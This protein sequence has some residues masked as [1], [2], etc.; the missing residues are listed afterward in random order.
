MRILA[1]GKFADLDEADGDYSPSRGR[2]RG[3]AADREGP[4]LPDF[5]E[6]PLDKLASRLS[7]AAYGREMV[8]RGI[9]LSAPPA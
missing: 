2:G 9:R 5:R 1:Q 3:S 4:A 8:S 6:M 7:V